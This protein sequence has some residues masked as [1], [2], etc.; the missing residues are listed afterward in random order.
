MLSTDELQ[1][2][3]SDRLALLDAVPSEPEPAVSTPQKPDMEDFPT[4]DE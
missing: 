1:E 3:L 2:L 4:D